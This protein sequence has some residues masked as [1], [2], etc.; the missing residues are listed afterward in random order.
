MRVRAPRALA[1]ACVASCVAGC[2]VSAFTCAAGDDAAACAALADL[3]AAASGGLQ[4]WSFAAAGWAAAAADTPTPL[5]SLNG[6][7]CDS[8][9]ALIGLCAPHSALR[10]QHQSRQ[11]VDARALRRPS[12]VGS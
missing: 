2:G 5:C 7:T 8:G 3:W 12:S 6:T 4:P 9:G 11:R 10:A 1:A